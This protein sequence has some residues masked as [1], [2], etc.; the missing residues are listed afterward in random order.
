MTKHHWFSRTRLPRTWSPVTWQGWALVGVALAVV[1]LGLL[2]VLMGSP[3]LATASAAV[4]LPAL[5]LLL[6][7]A[8]LKGPAP[9]WNWVGQDD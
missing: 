2:P 5:G 7:V 8:I 6:A 4:A 3:V 1:M 9:A